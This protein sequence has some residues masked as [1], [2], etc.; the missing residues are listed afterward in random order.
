MPIGTGAF[1]GASAASSAAQIWGQERANKANRQNAQDNRDFQERMS[2]TAY[3]RQVADMKAAG[4]NPMVAFGS[5][6]ASS[7]SG[8]QAQSQSS[9]A[10]AGK[11]LTNSAKNIIQNRQAAAQEKQVTSQTALNTA[12][13][14]KINAETIGQTAE[15][16]IQVMKKRWIKA[17]MDTA[18]NSAK[19]LK[20]VKKRF[21]KWWNSKDAINQKQKRD[22]MRK[23]F[24]H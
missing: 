12:A 18:E 6:G 23:R 21:D 7:P 16:D 20:N 1:L 15:N 14:A 9:T 19:G 3:Q 13:K 24:N 8:S 2:N 10:E 17:G 5:G 4:I 22:T 11:N